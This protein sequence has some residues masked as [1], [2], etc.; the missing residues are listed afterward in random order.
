MSFGERIAIKS[1]REIER[2]REVGQFTAEILL[3]L[4]DRARPGV[5][6]GQLDEIREESVGKEG[7]EFA[8]PGLWSRG[9]QT[10]PGCSVHLDQRGDRA[11]DPRSA[12]A[13]RGRHHQSRLRCR[14]RRL[15]RRQ[16]S[17]DRRRRDR[18]RSEAID[19]V[20]RRQL[21]ISASRRWFPAIDCRTS[22]TRCRHA[23][24]VRDTESFASSWDTASDGRCTKRRR[25]RITDGRGAGRG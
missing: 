8:I 20:R 15:A 17:D 10:L 24:R 3:E 25:C 12:R 6:T 21:S 2:M 5:T 14:V 23:R 9:G 13:P 7:V 19:R 16:R 22:A 18:C 4:R 1:R 11:R